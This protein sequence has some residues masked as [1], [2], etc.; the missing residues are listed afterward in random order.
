MKRA[1]R[2]EPRVLL[3][4]LLRPLPLQNRVC[5]GPPTQRRRVV[6][7]P[8]VVQAGSFIFEVAR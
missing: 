7:R 3:Q 8:G 2:Q 6:P 5:R 4:E 1:H